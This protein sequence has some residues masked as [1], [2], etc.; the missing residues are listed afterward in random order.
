MQA[1]IQQN[2]TELDTNS[3]LSPAQVQV[4]A[5][6]HA[7]VHR[8]TIYVWLQREPDFKTAIQNALREYI[9]TMNDEFRDL[10]SAA[11]KTLRD[12]LENPA[13]ADWI[14]LR[15]ALAVLNRPQFPKRGWN[16]P[17]RVDSPLAAQVIDGTADMEQVL[18][19]KSL[20]RTPA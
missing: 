6:L 12:L 2:S 10:S 15:T 5:A 8:T 11:L 20:R 14:R 1:A 3:R 4:A 18:Q 19:S 13:T 7:G 16:L 9:D 17:G